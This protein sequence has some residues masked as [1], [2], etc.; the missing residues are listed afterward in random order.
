M[1]SVWWGGY[2]LCLPPYWAGWA[3]GLFPQFLKS[4]VGQGRGIALFLSIWSRVCRIKR[5]PSYRALF[6]Q[7]YKRLER[8]CCCTCTHWQFQV[9][10]CSSAQAGICRGKTKNKNPT[11][12]TKMVTKA[13]KKK[14]KKKREREKVRER[15]RSWNSWSEPL[16][17]PCQGL[18]IVVLC[19]L[20]RVYGCNKQDNRMECTYFILFG[21]RNSLCFH[22]L[23][24]HLGV[25]S[26][27]EQLAQGY[28]F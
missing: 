12:H 14:K 20:S 24:P 4:W 22:G 2:H 7:V 1:H 27:H 8:V 6:F 15:K 21:T 11:K 18:L 17:S 25:S 5:A 28:S 9:V 13:K 23:V 16:L 10:V 19:I 26:C 3:A